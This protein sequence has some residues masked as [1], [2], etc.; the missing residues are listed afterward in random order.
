MAESQEGEAEKMKAPCYMR[1]KS[2]IEY[3]EDGKAYVVLECRIRRWA[4]LRL[5]RRAIYEQDMP[6][7]EKR[8]TIR[9]ILRRWLLQ[10]WPEREEA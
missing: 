7:S 10:Q 8:E 4:M 6:R 1:I 5:A 3:D 2:H 9:Y